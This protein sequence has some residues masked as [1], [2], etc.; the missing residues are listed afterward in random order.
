MKK[1]KIIKRF[2]PLLCATLL[3]LG[4]S[5]TAFAFT[6][7]SYYTQDDLYNI[8]VKGGGDMDRDSFDNSCKDYLV[9]RG[10]NNGVY[11]LVLLFN[12][13]FDDTKYVYYDEDEKVIDMEYTERYRLY[14][15]TG[16]D[17]RFYYGGYYFLWDYYG[18]GCRKLNVESTFDVIYSTTPIK[19]EN[20]NR[21]FFQMP[22]NQTAPGITVTPGGTIT[23]V[24]VEALTGTVQEQVTVIV[25]IA[26]GCLALLVGLTILAKKLRIFL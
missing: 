17:G 2:I 21:I 12:F 24:Q 16:T 25:P 14:T 20:S 23:P 4:S 11:N 8:Y 26:V 22:P 15:E 10:K 1:E 18:Y 6:Y 9:V 13:G 7:P 3:L 5:M 19:Y